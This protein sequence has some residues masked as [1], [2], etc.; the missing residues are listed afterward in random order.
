LK[1]FANLKIALEFEQIW[2]L[3]MIQKGPAKVT[4][5]R[6]HLKQVAIPKRANMGKYYLEHIE[7][8]RKFI[9]ELEAV[10]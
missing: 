4:P 7:F 1:K 9:R 5:S 3:K 10:G 6:L 2:T 8:I